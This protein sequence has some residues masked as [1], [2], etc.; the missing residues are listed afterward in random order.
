MV[1]I[2]KREDFYV[3]IKEMIQMIAKQIRF[4]VKVKM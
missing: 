2:Q 3:N 1:I 4:N